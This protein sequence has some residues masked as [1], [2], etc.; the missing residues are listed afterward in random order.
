MVI[1]D[2]QAALAVIAQVLGVSKAQG[3]TLPQVAKRVW[4]ALQLVAEPDQ[5]PVAPPL[6]IQAQ[7]GVEAAVADAI[8]QGLV[9]P[10]AAAQP[11]P[12][13]T[14]AQSTP[15]AEIE[16]D[17]AVDLDSLTAR[18]E[19]AGNAPPQ[20]RQ[21]WKLEDLQAAIEKIAP[22]SAPSPIQ[23]PG[24]PVMLLRKITQI[25]GA[26][27]GMDAIS[28][29][30]LPGNAA[31]AFGAPTEIFL[32]SEK[33]PDIEERVQRVFKATYQMLERRN[34]PVSVMRPPVPQGLG[35]ENGNRAEADILPNERA[36]LAGRAR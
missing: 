26:N 4:G 32:C 17:V 23:G 29:A 10:V 13:A 7:G 14:P 8:E 11:R 19:V 16:S 34:R 21:Y 24:G 22:A 1:R 9:P 12:V 2:E 6:V 18:Q 31:D 33:K 3:L 20:P 27:G 5:E 28:L 25:L 15:G 30:F 35:L 36:Y